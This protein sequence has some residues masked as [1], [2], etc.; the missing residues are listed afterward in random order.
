V[1]AA[2]RESAGGAPRKRFASDSSGTYW[3]VPIVKAKLLV[4]DADRG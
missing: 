2:F 3:K 4:E 1:S